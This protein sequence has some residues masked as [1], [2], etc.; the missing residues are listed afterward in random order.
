MSNPKE[1]WSSETLMRA[2]DTILI[3]K[4]N[5][6]SIGSLVFT[7]DNTE[8]LELWKRTVENLNSKAS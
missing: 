4:S 7:S 8:D 2:N 5:G 1:Q 6:V 3:I